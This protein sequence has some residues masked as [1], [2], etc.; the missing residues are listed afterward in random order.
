MQVTRAIA[1]KRPIEHRVKS[2]AQS[3]TIHLS[4]AD[5]HGNFASLSLTHGGS[6]GAKVTVDGL[7][8][9][10]GHGVSRFDVT[11]DHP[12]A[13]GPGKRPLHNMVPSIVTRDGQAILAV[14]GRGGRKIPNAMVTLLTEF[15]LQK[16]SLAASMAAPRMHTEGNL[17]LELE[18]NWPEKDRKKLTEFGYQVK[19]AGS[20]TLSAIAKD[21]ESLVTGMR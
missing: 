2:N 5:R 16:Q 4:S 12:N 21:G 1:T 19:T 18:K 7:G 14:G 15:V 13:P 9:T 10:L 17:G 11:P 6:F 20:A 3:G 8:L